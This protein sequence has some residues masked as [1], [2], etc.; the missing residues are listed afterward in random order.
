[1]C[2][3]V[4]R[5]DHWDYIWI[6]YFLVLFRVFTLYFT[7]KHFF[8]TIALL[9]PV[10]RRNFN[11]PI[12]ATQTRG[13]TIPTWCTY[14]FPFKITVRSAPPTDSVRCRLVVLS[15]SRST[16]SHSFH[17]ALKV[18]IES[19]RKRTDPWSSFFTKSPVS[20]SFTYST[21]FVSRIFE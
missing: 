16:F 20:W 12:V 11:I 3:V 6:S 4:F 2:L 19:P 21:A 15:K 10:K 13:S 18:I 1:M 14:A 8:P 17:L 5:A 7:N 9:I